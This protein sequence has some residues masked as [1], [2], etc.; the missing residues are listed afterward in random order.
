MVLIAVACAPARAWADCSRGTRP[1]TLTER[2]FQVATLRALKAAM[3]PAPDG[4][5]VVEE[6]EVKPPRLACIGQERQPLPVEYRIRFAEPDAAV[7]EITIRVNARREAVPASPEAMEVASAALAFRARDGGANAVRVL[8]GD[9]SL[10]SD[11]GGEALAHFA[12]DLPHTQAQSLA[13][14]IDGERVRVDQLLARLDV[15]ALAA[16]IR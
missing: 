11:G 12:A 2:T 3:P 1:T 4:W 16:L 15:G 10:G 6:T 14:R 5:R 13:V 7:S 8:F 9:W